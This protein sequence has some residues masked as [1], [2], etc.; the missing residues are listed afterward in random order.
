[1]PM[2]RIWCGGRRE[3]RQG[4]DLSMQIS[5]CL[6]EKGPIWETLSDI[7]GDGD[8]VPGLGTQPLSG[9]TALDE[10]LTVCLETSLHQPLGCLSALGLTIIILWRQVQLWTHSVITV[11]ATKQ[12]TIKR[13]K[14]CDSNMQKIEI[15]GR[16]L[17]VLSE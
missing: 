14:D 17:G 12:P 10:G 1:M 2:D 4:E 7:W 9:L 5:L 11:T 13:R 15:T 3:G 6:R 16:V 8:V